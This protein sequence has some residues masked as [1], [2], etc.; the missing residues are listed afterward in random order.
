[1]LKKQS[2]FVVNMKFLVVG[3]G[4]I[5]ER[6]IKNLN[7]LGPRGGVDKIF[8]YDKNV[9]RLAELEKKYDIKICHSLDAGLTE[10]P[11]AVLVCT[12]TNTHISVAMRALKQNCHIFIEKPISHNM[13]S[14]D[15]F[16]TTAKRQNRIIAVGYNMRFHPGLQLVKKM[17]GSNKF[18]KVLVAR[19]EYGQ[20]MPDWRPQQ[21]YKKIYSA[22]KFEGGGIILDASHEIDY[23]MWLLGDVKELM[24]QA[25][26]VSDLKID[27]EDAADILIRFNSG[28]LANIHLDALQKYYARSCKLICEKGIIVWDYPKNI[29]EVFSAKTCQRKIFKIKSDSNDMYLAEITHF[30][31][32]I[33]NKKRPIVT[34]DDGKKTLEIALAAKKSAEIGMGIKL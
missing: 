9:K 17:L 24:C 16:L 26:K 12:P 31:D 30:I 2:K 19:A 14:V 10:S 3:C 7:K 34:G 21:D 11:N 5:G 6:H 18:G 13:V 20:Y 8:A 33:R 4:S 15:K 1:M 27:V 22:K 23:I 28:A 25:D 29:V 32:C